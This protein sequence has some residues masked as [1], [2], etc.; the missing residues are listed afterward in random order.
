MIA[1]VLG[2]CSPV[3]TA[4]YEAAE[5]NP[6]GRITAAAEIDRDGG[7]I[8]LD[9]GLHRVYLSIPNGAVQTRYLIT[10]SVTTTEEG[11]MVELGPEDLVFSYAADLKL[12]GATLVHGYSDPTI[13][14]DALQVRVRELRDPIEVVVER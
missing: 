2:G 13:L 4:S 7:G 10:M 6:P 12:N 3:V 9:D 8:L 11:Y 1:V 14:P 5:E